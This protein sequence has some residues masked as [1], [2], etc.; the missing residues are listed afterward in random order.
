MTILV[1][2]ATG[3]VGRHL[4]HEL[5]R[6]GHRVRALSRDPAKAAL[7]PEVE[8][9]G[10]NLGDPDTLAGAFDGVDAVHLITLDGTVPLET[11]QEVVDLAVKAGVRRVTVLWSGEAGAVERAV[12]AGGLEWT[13]LEPVEFM[14][15]ALGWAETIRAEGVV[16]EAFPQVLSAMVHEGDIARVAAAALIGDGH[17]GMSYTLT[18]PEALTVP[19]KVRILAAV[20]GREI[21]YVERSKA[22]ARERLLR[23]GVR[24]DVVD[25]VVGWHEDPPK[26]AYTVVPVVQQVTGRRSRTF[27]EWT[28]EHAAAFGR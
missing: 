4:V 5:L 14:S 27:G 8:V 20:L 16:R 11:G 17:A 2:G 25:F 24:D 7:P 6:G 1:T 28:A 3:N 21:R 15:N 23:S 26:E 12:E 13:R 22:E 19:D 18:G 10:G 9:A